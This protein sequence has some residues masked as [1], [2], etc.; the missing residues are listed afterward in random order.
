MIECAVAAVF[1]SLS[2]LVFSVRCVFVNATNSMQTDQPINRRWCDSSA[3]INSKIQANRLAESNY[4][5]DWLFICFCL[6]DFRI[7]CTLVPIVVIE[8]CGWCVS[9][10]L[11]LWQKDAFI[12]HALIVP[13]D[14]WFNLFHLSYA[15]L[16]YS[17][18]LFWQCIS[19][20]ISQASTRIFIKPKN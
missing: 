17:T 11:R 8:W 3:I 9:I 1:F 4:N 19:H 16:K 15:A 14:L 7:C 20:A 13:F 2:F 5:L 12:F 6:Y 10:K 18:W